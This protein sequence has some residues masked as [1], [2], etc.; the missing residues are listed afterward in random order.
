MLSGVKVFYFEN[1]PGFPVPVSDFLICSADA[2]LS[3]ID[4]GR[5]VR[6]AERTGTPG[7]TTSIVEIGNDQ[8]ESGCKL[9][10]MTLYLPL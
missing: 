10:T 6:G 4:W 5:I 8:V 2:L 9:Q 7:G 1:W 3:K